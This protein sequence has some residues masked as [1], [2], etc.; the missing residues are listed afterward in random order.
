MFGH[1][2]LLLGN[3]C[4]F[5]RACNR[6]ITVPN[7]EN[8]YSNPAR[9]FGNARRCDEWFVMSPRAFSARANQQL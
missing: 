7:P 3:A 9:A 1:V 8:G 6:T 4:S 2:A 5:H